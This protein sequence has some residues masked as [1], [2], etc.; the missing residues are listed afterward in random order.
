MN[1]NFL[2][3]NS[4]I[5]SKNKSKEICIIPY[6]KNKMKI[7]I[8]NSQY[9]ILD[10]IQYN[11]SNLMMLIDLEKI[12]KIE[13]EFQ[14]P[15]N[16]EEDGLNRIEFIKILKKEINFTDPTTEINLVYPEIV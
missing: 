4:N 5:S 1:E 3:Y 7:I 8:N 6:Q 10:P 16:T 15:N 2:L 12:Y 13:K 14:N 11:I 9:F